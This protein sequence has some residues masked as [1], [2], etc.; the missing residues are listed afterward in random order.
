[1]SEFIENNN[2]YS[3]CTIQF[4]SFYHFYKTKNISVD[5]TSDY[6]IRKGAYR[7]AIAVV[8][9]TDI[10]STT[11]QLLLNVRTTNQAKTPLLLNGF[12]KILIEAT[13]DNQFPIKYITFSTFDWLKAKWYFDCKHNTYDVQENDSDDLASSLAQNDQHKAGII[14]LWFLLFLLSFTFFISIAAI[15]LMVSPHQILTNELNKIYIHFI[16]SGV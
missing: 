10:L 5:G 11:V 4:Q 1:M 16:C 3:T 8:K 9:I 12:N 14:V 2:R 6:L 15:K 13:V 7:D